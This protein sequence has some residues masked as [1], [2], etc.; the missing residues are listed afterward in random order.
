M[1][2]DRVF[3]KEMKL[4]KKLLS[5]LGVLVI[6]GAFAPMAHADFV[7]AYSVNGG[8]VTSCADSPD[9]TIANCASPA[10]SIGGGVKLKLASGTSNSPGDPNFANQFGSTTTVITGAA[11]ATVVLY[12]AAQNFTM[13]VTGGSVSAINYSSE[14]GVSTAQPGGTGTIALESCVDE[15][16]HTVPGPVG[17]G[18]CTT[19]AA[20][21][22]NLTLT[23][24]STGS[25]NNT[26]TSI[27]TPLG[28]PYS[29]SQMVTLMLGANTSVGITTSQDLTPVPEPVS[30]ALLGGVL[31]LT[32]RAFRRKQKKASGV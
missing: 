9:D 32:A 30:I 12:F 28:S 8:T 21:L 25:V 1:V 14:L 27:F 26:V 2:N 13:P 6:A 22:D 7:I 19:P 20:K 31:A 24:P 15:S 4:M 18:Y 3:N 23:L 29:L 16:N 10:I 17:A 5:L 11:G